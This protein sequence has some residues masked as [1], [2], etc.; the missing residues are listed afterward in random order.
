MN[1]KAP[2][3]HAKEIV[4]IV[5]NSLGAVG[6]INALAT[7]ACRRQQCMHVGQPP[8]ALPPVIARSARMLVLLAD[9]LTY[10]QFGCNSGHSSDNSKQ[11]CLVDREHGA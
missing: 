2:P 3:Q 8:I 1:W 4:P 7:S 11:Y 9:A 5:E 10:T 6:L